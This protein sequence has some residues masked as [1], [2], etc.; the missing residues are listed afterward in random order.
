MKRARSGD[1]TAAFEESL[2]ANLSS[3][4]QLRL[5]VTGVTPRSVRAIE[6]IK[7]LCEAYLKGR[8]EL[9]VVDI[10]QQPE[11]AKQ[12]DILASPTLIKLLPRPLRRFIGDLTKTERL[13]AGLDLRVGG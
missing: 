2:K 8:Y 7:Q 11:L 5:F 3:H 13:I 12:E 10:Y 4:Y 9:T 6:N 1:S